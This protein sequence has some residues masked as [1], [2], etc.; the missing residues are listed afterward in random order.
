MTEYTTSSQAVREY[1]TSRERTAY[2][3]QSHEETEFYSPSAPPSALDGWI[4]SSPVSEAES[5]HSVPPRMVLR[6]GNGV[7][8]VPIPNSA[9]PHRSGRSRHRRG[10]SGSRSPTSTTT[11]TDFPHHHRTRSGSAPLAHSGLHHSNAYAEYAPPAPEEIRVLP[12][13]GPPLPHPSSSSQPRSKSLPR[14][15]EFSS[16]TRA[17]GRPGPMPR[18]RTPYPHGPSQGPTPPGPVAQPAPFA[19]QPWH[20]YA[21]GRP[22]HHTQKQ[23]PA[24][25]YAPS[26]TSSRP[27]YAP[28]A[29]YHHPPQMGP[30]GMIYS[31]SAPV[32]SSTHHGHGAGLPSTM[33]PP[34]HTL[35]RLREEEHHAGTWSGRSNKRGGHHQTRS[36][37]LVP[38]P[39]SP[40]SSSSSLNS[41]ESGSTYY[42]LPSAGQKVHVISPSPP[43]SIGTATST[44]RSPISPLKKAPF[45]QRLFSFAGKFSVASSTKASSTAGG[46]TGRRLQRRHSTGGA[47]RRP[48]VNRH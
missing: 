39:L 37:S 1:M 44:T 41:G 18:T 12:S 46:T 23:P 26:H 11:S 43:R 17:P 20:P 10:G 24:I 3:V 42:V 5:S 22:Q 25:I 9:E 4:P 13:H 21:Q 15:T 27:R 19:P 32:H 36:L 48:E 2:W 34:S 7:P 40:A 31:H 47:G 8:D 45:L 30:N 14:S 29:M 28:P 16:Q 38:P 6:W 33:V 35:A